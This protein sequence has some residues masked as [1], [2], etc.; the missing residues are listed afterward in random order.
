MLTEISFQ[1]I[2]SENVSCKSELTH[3]DF[4]PVCVSDEIWSESVALTD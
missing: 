1:L 3:T 2:A 4:K